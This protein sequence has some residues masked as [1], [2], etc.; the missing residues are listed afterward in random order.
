[1]K[2]V[3]KMPKKVDIAPKL[4][5]NPPKQLGKIG[6][7]MYRKITPYLD[8]L[9]QVKPI[10]ANL[11]EMYCSAYEIYRKAYQHIQEHGSV[12]AVYK[13]VISPTGKI[14]GKDFTGYKRNPS[15]QIY[16]DALAKLTKIGHELGLSPD[17]RDKLFQIKEPEKKKGSSATELKEFFNKKQA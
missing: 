9:N 1:M 8:G 16:S 13:T 3:D 7:A 14:G 17:G 6:A 11:V 10:D 12:Q 4:S 15:T 5:K 2:G